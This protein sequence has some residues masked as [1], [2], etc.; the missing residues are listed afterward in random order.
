MKGR[1]LTMNIG[2]ISF[3]IV[4]IILC[5]VTFSVLSLVSANSNM[6]MTNRS[7]EHNQEYYQ[8]SSQGEAYLE[9]I[10]DYLYQMY[11]QYS[12]EQYFQQLDHIKTIIP[13]ISISNH[14]LYF[15]ITGDKQKLEIEI[16]VLYPGNKL[17]EIKSWKVQSIEEWNPDQKIDVL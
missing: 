17:Y 6:N 5:L 4:F 10:D 13:D 15:T 14:Y 9:K 8:L 3:M 16:E 11:Q 12:K 2:I 7:I 1:K